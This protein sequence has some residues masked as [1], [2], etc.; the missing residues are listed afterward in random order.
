MAWF[1][2]DLINRQGPFAPAPCAADIA[3]FRRHVEAGPEQAIAHFMRPGHRMTRRVESFPK[4]VVA[5]VNGLAFGGGCEL[6][7]SAHIALAAD[8]ATFSKAE[9]KRFGG[10]TLRRVISP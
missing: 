4:P 3:E 7:E 8:T 1:I 10:D 5:A 2:S 6:V 9:G